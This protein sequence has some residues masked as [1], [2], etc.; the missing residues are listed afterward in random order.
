[1]SVTQCFSHCCRLS[2]DLFI[3]L[4]VTLFTCLPALGS[5]FHS[6]NAALALHFPWYVELSAL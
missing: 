1:M 4:L 5:G 2:C 3:C 6:R